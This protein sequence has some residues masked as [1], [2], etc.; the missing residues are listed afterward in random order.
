MSALIEISAYLIKTVTSFY[1]GLV[2]IRFLLQV[3]KADFYN[4]ISQF[5]V[6]ATNPGL[7]PLRKIIPGLWGLDIASV[8]LAI[9]IQMFAIHAI[10][11]L[12]GYGF[13][14][15]VNTLIWS[16][17]AVAATATKFLFF[18]I[19]ISIVFSWLAPSS[20]H[21]ALTLLHQINEPIL[22]PVRRLLPAM[23]GLDFSPILVFILLNIVDIL[24]R[25]AAASVGM[26]SGLTMVM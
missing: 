7:L 14:S 26:L 1:I 9:I 22:G 8:V 19:I 23:G 5:V 15:P 18:S 25:N 13:G 20:S 21:P 6:K 2:I 10:L 4:P 12:A 24:I 17:I 16:L 3:A 11:L